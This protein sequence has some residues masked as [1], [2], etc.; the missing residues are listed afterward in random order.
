MNRFLKGILIL[1]FYISFTS[2]SKGAI[3]KIT[4]DDAISPPVAEYVVSSINDAKNKKYDLIIIILNTPGGLE[5]STREI[6]DAILTSPTPICVY[7]YPSGARAA[8]AGA[9]I[10]LASHILAMSP[11]SNI[12]A[13]HPTNI[14]GEIKNKQ[15]ETKIVNDLKAYVRSLAE[16]RKR[17]ISV[18]ESFVEKSL[19]LTSK[20]AKE[21]GIAD[22]IAEDVDI[23]LQKI[24]GFEYRSGN[25]FGKLTLKDKNIE[26]FEM[27]ITIKIL[28]NLTNPNLT[29]ILMMIGIF[30]LFFELSNPGLIIP[31]LLGVILI[32]LSFYGFHIL[33]ADIVGII[34][35]FIGIVLLAAEVFIVSKGLLSLG[36]IASFIIGNIMLYKS[37][38]SALG[39]RLG[40][41]ISLIIVTF[42]II[43]VMLLIGIK[44]QFK[45]PLE[46]LE[47]I[48]GLEGEC[49][50]ISNKKTGKVFVRGEIWN[51]EF[52]DNLNTGDKITV[53][54]Y[55]NNI[56]IVKR[57]INENSV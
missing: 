19:S 29:Y 46:G 42:G 24:E 7:V 30:F 38:D 39:F 22:V 43:L 41:M 25:F 33:S 48:I 4:I 27:P 18:A 11:V 40:Y 52:L 14:A 3:A 34:F 9:L 49:I 50:S 35:I 6:V 2:E 55:K 32:L 51:A 1:F 45:K 28:K 17:N 31:G 36:G 44:A 54:G 57:S 53:V 5:Q 56:L 15:L 23:L 12:G 21:Q 16:L 8:S 26:N 47:S 10:A 20:E 37:L 13:A